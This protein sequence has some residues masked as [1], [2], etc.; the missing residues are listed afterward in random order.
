MENK[1]IKYGLSNNIGLITINRP[2]KL[3]ALNHETLKELEEL[4]DSIKSDESKVVIIT[5]EGD[6]AF[7]AGADINEINVL[8]ANSAKEFSLF[9]Q[10][11]FNKIELLGK[12]VIAAVNGFALGGGCELALACHIRIVSDD[13]NF[14]QPEIKLGIIP[15]YGGTQRLPRVIGHSKAIEYSLTGEMINSETAKEIGLVNKVV[16]KE[17]LLDEA[18]SLAGRIAQFSGPII[19]NLL[20]AIVSSGEKVL[21]EGLNNEA[22]LFAACCNSEDFKEGTSAFLEKRKPDF[23]DK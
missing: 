7:V 21:S 17:K 20:N 4:L 11:V 1:N 3:N 19:N 13:A 5:G 6:K 18:Y 22:A 10:S 12:P 8:D 14:G 16:P 2:D 15:G 9:G 23:K